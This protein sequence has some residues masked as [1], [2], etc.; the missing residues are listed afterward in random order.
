M[1]PVDRAGEEERGVGAVQRS[2][3]GKGVRK[4]VVD[5]REGK[6]GEGRQ[7]EA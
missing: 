2:R 5:R 3:E 6:G 1:L 7:K 4:G